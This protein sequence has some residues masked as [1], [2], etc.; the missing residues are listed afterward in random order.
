MAVAGPA[1]AFECDKA[2]SKAEKAICADP[3]AKAADDA[4]NEAFSALRARLDPAQRTALLAN[5]RR[6]L[7]TRDG[8]CIGEDRKDA[9]ACLRDENGARTL[10]LSARPEAG[11]GTPNPLLPVFL[12][13]AGTKTTYDASALLYRFEVPRGAA[14]ARLNAW[15]EAMLKE[16]PVRT[17]DPGGTFTYSFE[18]RARIG[19]ASDRLLSI[20]VTGY[21]FTGGAHGQ[22]SSTALN[23]D[24][25][26]GRA[27]AIGDLVGP[28]E[29]GEV[30]ATCRRDVARD[31][32][33]RLTEGGEDPGKDPDAKNNLDVLVRN[34]AEP[35]D[36]T[37]GDLANWSFGA[38]AATVTFVSDAIGPHAMGEFAC[39]LPYDRLRGLAKPGFPLPS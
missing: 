7:K 30:R 15:T 3:A 1:L 38:K 26:A 16:A 27:L 17:D 24:L 2:R 37:V 39:T 22:S 14:E 33:A 6:W 13:R 21:D 11:P 29:L 4:M 36:A 25:K 23:L 35:V 5:Q 28:K 19:Y 18:R 34:A 12:E 31:I 20:T 9:S 8:A 32:K 10:A